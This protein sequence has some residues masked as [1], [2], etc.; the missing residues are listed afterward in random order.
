M[1]DRPEQDRSSTEC[2]KEW[3]HVCMP[4]GRLFSTELNQ[5]PNQIEQR[6][7]DDHPKQGGHQTGGRLCL[8]N[9]QNMPHNQQQR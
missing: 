2:K 4:S 5:R 9:A 8:L 1:G 7:N 6:I 3:G